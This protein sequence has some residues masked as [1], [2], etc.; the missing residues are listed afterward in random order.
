MSQLTFDTLEF[1]KTLEKAGIPKEHA[2]A[3]TTAQKQAFGDMV[4]ARD[5]AAKADIQELKQEMLEL[6]NRLEVKMANMK[7]DLIKWF[8]GTILTIL[9]FMF[10]GFGMIISR[11]P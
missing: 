4:A 7:T 5:L 10:A 3:I 8:M 1:V 9:G 11:L 2:E 6:E